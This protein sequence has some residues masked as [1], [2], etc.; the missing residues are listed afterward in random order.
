MLFVGFLTLREQKCWLMCDVCDCCCCAKADCTKGELR[1]NFIKPRQKYHHT[2]PKAQCMLW[3]LL[4]DGFLNTSEQN[5]GW[6]V[7]R[8]VLLCKNTVKRRFELQNE[9]SSPIV[10]VTYMIYSMIGLAGGQKYFQK[11]F[12]ARNGHLMC[13]DMFVLFVVFVHY[14]KRFASKRNFS[15]HIPYCML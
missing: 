15:T 9:F 14:I 1:T 6:C 5:F 8:G 2:Y 7:M 3:V 11:K 12:L 4:L 10:D 13:V